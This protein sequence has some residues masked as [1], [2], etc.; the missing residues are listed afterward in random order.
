MAS[1]PLHK[2]KK[3]LRTAAFAIERMRTASTFGAFERAWLDFLSAVEKAWAKVGATCGPRST[4]FQPWQGGY[5]KRRR[6]DPLLQYLEQARN[7]DHHGLEESVAYRPGSYTAVIQG[8]VEIESMT[9]DEHGRI[10]EYVGNVAPII[11]ETPPRAVLQAIRNR[12]ETYLPPS[13]HAGPPFIPHDPIWVAETGLTFFV[14]YVA[15]A[16]A[17]FFPPGQK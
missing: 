17:V 1:D 15:A 7:A 9:I 2:A 10:S 4:K 14:E 11:R 8:D 3:E 16:E 6:E 12:G 5:T 13:K